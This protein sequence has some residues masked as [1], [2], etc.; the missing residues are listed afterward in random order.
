MAAAP[1][2]AA[3]PG[4]GAPA[5]APPAPPGGGAPEP[6]PAAAPAAPTAT[7]PEKTGPPKK[8]TGPKQPEFHAKRDLW[9]MSYPVLSVAGCENGRHLLSCGGGGA[10]GAKEVPNEVHL[11]IYDSS[12]DPP[13]FTTADRLNLGPTLPTKVTYSKKQDLWCVSAGKNGFVLE[14]IEDRLNVVYEFQSEFIP[15]PPL[16]AGMPEGNPTQEVCLLGHDK[17]V[18][19][20]S[21]K[22]AR[23]WSYPTVSDKPVMEF[24]KHVKV[25]ESMDLSVDDRWGLVLMNASLILIQYIV[26]LDV[27]SPRI[28]LIRCSSPV[29]T[30][31]CSRGGKKNI[32]RLF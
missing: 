16:R 9:F 22:V 15:I 7:A 30:F 11:H 17:L 14:I 1:P 2:T 5:G 27:C 8:A 13:S 31:H 20:G 21:D 32:I 3:G 24:T 10:A 4:R 26:V 28:V 23:V 19:A 29:G 25:I 6:A 18:T 12:T